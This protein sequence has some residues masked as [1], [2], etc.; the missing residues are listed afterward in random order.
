MINANKVATEITGV[1]SETMKKVENN[2]LQQF[3]LKEPTSL[4]QNRPHCVHYG[5]QGKIYS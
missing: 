5:K 3:G 1:D 2:F 4:L